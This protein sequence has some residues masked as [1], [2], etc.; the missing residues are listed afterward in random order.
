M[1]KNDYFDL[2]LCSHYTMAH[3]VLKKIA[4]SCID[5]DVGS[6]V[7]W[8]RYIGEHYTKG[9]GMIEAIDLLCVQMWDH[10]KEMI[11]VSIL[12]LTTKMNA[13][14]IEL[15]HDTTSVEIKNKLMVTVITMAKACIDVIRE[16]QKVVLVIKFSLIHACSR[17]KDLLEGELK[18]DQ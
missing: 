7:A 8:Y 11:E 9:L 6:A 16:S 3:I 14:L 2:E 12:R 18:L 10:G 17:Y 1:E 5:K 15:S 13:L 4:E